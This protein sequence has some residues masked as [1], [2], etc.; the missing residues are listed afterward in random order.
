MTL[1]SERKRELTAQY[2]ANEHDTGNT[3]VQ[4][5]Q[6]TERI[7][8]LTEHLREHRSGPPL[9]PRP[10]DAGRQPAALPQLPAAHRPRGLPRVD[11]VARAAQV[12]VIEAGTP[13]AGVHADEGGRREVHARG[14]ARPHERPR[15]LPVRVQPRLQRPADAL[16]GGPRRV[17]R[18]RRDAVRDLDRRALVAGG[19]QGEARQLGRAALRLRA[20]GRDGARLRRAARRRLHAARAGDRRPRRGRQ[21]GATRRRAP[22][23]CR[24]PT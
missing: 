12:S 2:G 15:L 22:A 17:H 11:R 8:G 6:L 14:P 16:R 23:S 7:N 13:V 21:A 10:A 24:A 3:K 1:T 4:I 9:A 19:V 5:A 18:A 20:Q